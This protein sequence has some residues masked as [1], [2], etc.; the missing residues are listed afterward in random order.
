MSIKSSGRIVIE[1]DPDLKCGLY[2][3][4][5]AKGIILKDRFVSQAER[6]MLYAGQT[7]LL[8]DEAVEETNEKLYS[9]D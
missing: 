8:A 4:L 6:F 1:I 2:S 5:T 9:K 3:N 7:P